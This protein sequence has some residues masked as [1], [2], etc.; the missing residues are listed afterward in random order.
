MEESKIEGK[1]LEKAVIVNIQKKKKKKKNIN[2]NQILKNLGKF[3]IQ[4]IQ[5]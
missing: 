3:K 5:I 1:Q 2:P 4:I